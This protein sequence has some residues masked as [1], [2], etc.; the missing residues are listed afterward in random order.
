MYSIIKYDENNFMSYEQINNFILMRYMVFDNAESLAVRMKF[1]FDTFAAIDGAEY[2]GSF[3]GTINPVVVQAGIEVIKEYQYPYRV[4]YNSDEVEDVPNFERL[5]LNPVYRLALALNSN[6]KQAACEGRIYD[7][8][9]I[10]GFG[11]CAVYSPLKPTISTVLTP[12]KYYLMDSE[13]V[14]ISESADKPPAGV[15]Y[16]SSVRLGSM[17]RQN[18]IQIQNG[19]PTYRPKG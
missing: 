16:F 8:A 12:I 13:G 3:P 1:Y 11:T 2:L 19:K 14:L 10:S 4:F 17:F 18:I 6:E 5:T 7:L 15:N 9:K